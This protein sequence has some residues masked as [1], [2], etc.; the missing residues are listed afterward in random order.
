MRR[1][2]RDVEETLFVAFA[3]V[4]LIIYAFLRSWRS[5]VIPVIAI[6]VS[7]V[8]S[9]FVMYV[10]GF[11]INVLTLVAIVL[12]IGLVCD[13]AIVVLENIHAKVEEGMS[14]LE[15]A[16]RGSKEIYFAVV[17]T[18]L[19]LAAVFVPVI[20]MSGL[21]GRLFREF[22]IVLVGSVLVSAF[23]ALTLSPMMCRFLLRRDARPS[24]FYRWSEPFFERLTEGYRRSLDAFMG[25]R[26]VVFPLLA[27]VGAL[28]VLAAFSLPRELAPLED[29]SNIRMNVRG[30]EGASYEFM[31]H[32]M[33]RIALH[34]KDRVPEV[35]HSLAITGSGGMGVNNGLFSVYLADP[36][37]RSRTQE[38]IFRQISADVEGF[39]G[40]RAFPAQPPTIGDRRAGQPVQYVL[41][42]ATLEELMGVLPKFLEE[43][44]ASPVLRFADADLKVNR[45]EGSITIDRRRAAELGVSVHDVARTLQLAYGGVRF[46]Y[47]LMRGRQYQVIGQVNREDRN[48]PADLGKLYVRT[49]SG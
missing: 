37:M 23:V 33:D 13:D 24:L 34:L 19:A 41:Q 15:A 29:R 32:H 38:E 1:A 3:L 14:P 10:A 27:G 45:P 7:I 43:A 9:F 22:G 42:A 48:D 18:T 11:T 46:G 21:S 4:A 16:L 44:A 31:D 6:P 39:S 35:E 28:I 47:F 49:R 40:V 36:T 17:S 30:P 5:T 20:F 25:V 12:A 2:I 8:S 26:W